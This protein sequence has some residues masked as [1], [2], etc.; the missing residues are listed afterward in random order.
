MNILTNSTSTALWH[1][2]IH[3][4]ESTCRITLEEDIESYLVFLLMRYTNKPELLKQIIALEFLEGINAKPAKQRLT[5]QEVG[6]KCL[7]FAGLY[8][9]MAD[10]RLVKISYFVN[11]GQACYVRIS[12]KNDDLYEGLGKQ[13]VSL[14][15]V[16]QSIR[17]YPDLLPLQAYELWSD[18]GSHRA[19]SIL[20]QYTQSAEGIPVLIDPKNYRNK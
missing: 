9:N 7:L 12:Q 13:F 10:K 3:E 8:P 1:E 6:D 20:R 18:T 5:L 17:Q 16:L 11:L 15:D 19:L 4:A 14:M 2:I